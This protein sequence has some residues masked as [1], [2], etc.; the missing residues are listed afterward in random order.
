MKKI[1][2]VQRQLLESN[3]YHIIDGNENQLVQLPDGRTLALYPDWHS[4][5]VSQLADGDE[6]TVSISP[7]VYYTD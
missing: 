5:P 3:G 6:F 1:S 7:N 2:L 4:V